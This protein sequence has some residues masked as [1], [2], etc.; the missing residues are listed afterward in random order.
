MMT[1]FH[2]DQER[3]DMHSRANGHEKSCRGFPDNEK[4]WTLAT[5]GPI[6]GFLCIEWAMPD[7]K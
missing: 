6:R 7:S 3:I 5:L 1:A 2:H 4:E